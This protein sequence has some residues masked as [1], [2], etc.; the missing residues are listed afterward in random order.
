MVA[1]RVKGQEATIII[2]RAGVVEDTLTDIHNFGLTFKG[3]LKRQGYLGE[4]TDRTDD[5]FH[6]VDFDFEMHTHTEDWLKF[7]TALINRQ[8][9]NDPTLVINIAVSL[10]YPDQDNPDIFIPDAK[11]G[12]IPMT[13]PNRADYV[14]VKYQGGA[15]D[16]DL[17]LT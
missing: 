13:I 17:Q 12:E 5:V 1:Q 4:K 16:Y 15:D 11:F 3:E 8:K 6:G 10:L 14:N 9:R 2:T 7:V